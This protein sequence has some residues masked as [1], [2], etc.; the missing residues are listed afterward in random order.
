MNNLKLLETNIIVSEKE[1]NQYHKKFLSQGYEGS[2]IRHGNKP[3]EVDKRSDSLL[4][5]KSF[6]DIAAII[7][8]ILPSEADPK[9]GVPV[10]RY[11]NVTFEAGTAFSHADREDLLTN[12]E[13]YINKIGEIRFF[14]Y[15]DSGKPRFPVLHGI[16]LDK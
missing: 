14:E 11:N 8:D 2:I 10:L 13:K 7:I 1:L 15:T 5:Y 12:K 4:K 3:Y 9:K 6:Q 16:R